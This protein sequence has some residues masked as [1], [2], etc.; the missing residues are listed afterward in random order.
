M[1]G[2]SEEVSHLELQGVRVQVA[3][4]LEKRKIVEA[5]EVID[6]VYKNDQG[7]LASAI[8]IDGVP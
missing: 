3:L 6:A 7:D 2:G 5:C 4:P 8:A 1:A